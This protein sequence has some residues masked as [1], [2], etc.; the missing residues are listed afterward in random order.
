M[1]SPRRAIV[2]WTDVKTRTQ[3]RQHDGAAIGVLACTEKLQGPSCDQDLLS[4][5]GRNTAWG[6]GDRKRFAANHA[7]GCEIVKAN[8]QL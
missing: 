6:K 5:G 7:T 1:D 4:A 8:S 3:L 2:G